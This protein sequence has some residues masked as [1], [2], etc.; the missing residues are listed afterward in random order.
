MALKSSLDR[1]IEELLKFFDGAQVSL[2]S[3][4][5]RFI[6]DTDTDKCV[7]WKSLKSSLDRFIGA[8][9]EE[10]GTRYSYFKIQFG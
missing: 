7:V 10:H 1:F 3:S 5:D 6:V 9:N 8:Y 4:L 2:K